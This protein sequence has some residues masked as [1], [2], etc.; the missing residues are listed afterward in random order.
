MSK[1][2]NDVRLAVSAACIEQSGG[3]IPEVHMPAV[4]AAR[5]VVAMMKG[6]DVVLAL[7]PLV[8]SGKSLVV[9][10]SP[11]RP[12]FEPFTKKGPDSWL[13]R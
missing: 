8:R 12:P 3:T 5:S 4:T 11:P 7:V 6:T 9:D 2:F 13:Q 10:L 1:Q